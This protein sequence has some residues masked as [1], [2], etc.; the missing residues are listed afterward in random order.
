[1]GAMGAAL[2]SMV[3]R[4]TIGRPRYAAVSDR[5]QVVLDQSESLRARLT[6]LGEDDVRAYDRVMAAYRL[7]RE[8]AAQQAERAAAVQAALREATD[9]PLACVRACR[10]VLALAAVALECG[11]VNARGDAG[12]G[13]LAAHAALRAAAINV[14]ANVG[15]VTDAAFVQSHLADLA[16]LLD[17]Q[18]ALAGEI[19]AAVSAAR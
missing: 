15:S 7:P 4:L 18:D 9:V 19:A 16:S 11:N 12:V 3:C 14:R 2:V 8:T 6:A 10:D 1:M 5:L 17:G 13:A